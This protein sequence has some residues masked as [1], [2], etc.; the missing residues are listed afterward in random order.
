MILNFPTF[1]PEHKKAR[2]R[3]K[4]SS[5]DLIVELFEHNRIT[6]R[7]K[8]YLLDPWEENVPFEQL[9]EAQKKLLGSLAPK[10]RDEF[11]SILYLA[12]NN[13]LQKRYIDWLMSAI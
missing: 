4:Y 13:G 1:P 2:P 10:F 12:E 11:L 3:T 9:G 8:T 7:Q 6:C 5:N